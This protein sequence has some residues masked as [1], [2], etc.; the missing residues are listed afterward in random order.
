MRH[1]VDR[2]KRANEVDGVPVVV[3]V[4]MTRLGVLAVAKHLYSGCL[5]GSRLVPIDLW[6]AMDNE[7]QRG[8]SM[9]FFVKPPAVVGSKDG[10]SDPIDPAFE[11]KWPTLASY[12]TKGAWP[13]GEVRKRSSLVLFCEDGAF[14]GCLSE[15]ELDLSLWATGKTFTGLLD[16][17]EARLTEDR[18]E[19]RAKPTKKKS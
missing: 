6:Q 12:L 5:L 16:G 19:W 14:K 13:D 9:S 7:Q 18:P 10:G 3:R 11:K 8:V 4:R 2:E 17:L 1:W 15:R